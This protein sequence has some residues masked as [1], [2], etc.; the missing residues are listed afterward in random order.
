MHSK[1]GNSEL[2]YRVKLNSYSDNPVLSGIYAL[3]F[4]GVQRYLGSSID[5][6]RRYK[7]H[8][9][10]LKRNAHGNRKLQSYY[11]KHGEPDLVIIEVVE[12]ATEK[13]VQ[14][15]E[16]TYLDVLDFSEMCNLSEVAGG[17][18]LSDEI[19]DKRKASLKKFFANNPDA[20]R[21]K[22]NP[23]FGRKH[24]QETKDAI[25][26]ANRGLKRSEEWKEQKAADM[27]SRKGS[28]HSEEH[29][30]QLKEKWS[31]GG[32][33]AAQPIE[34]EGILYSSK[35]ELMNAFGLTNYYQLSK[36]LNA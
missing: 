9:N 35:K 17:G 6:Q 36:F 28:F 23:F 3:S 33:P 34:H 14:E 19:N 13:D 15:L 29:K 12:R 21:G 1:R 32:N 4:S 7:Q 18:Y 22:N 10:L 24:T 30:Q 31:G 16:Q 26:N 2:N 25:G 20:I 11:N 5:I 8:L 27:R